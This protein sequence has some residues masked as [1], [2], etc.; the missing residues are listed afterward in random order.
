MKVRHLITS[1]IIAACTVFTVACGVNNNSTTPPGAKTGM[2]YKSSGFADK[3]YAIRESDMTGKEL[4]TVSSL[5]G[6]LAQ[7][8]AAVYIEGSVGSDADMLSSA[9]R[10]YGFEVEYVTDAW[11][12]VGKFTNALGGKY[13]LYND[14]GD[15]GVSSRDLSINYAAVVS[16]VE[17]YVMVAKSDEQAAKDSGFTLGKDATELSTREVFD[18]YMDRLNKGVLVH[19]EPANRYLRDYAIASKAMCFYSDYYDGDSDVKNDILAWADDNAPILGWTENEI[20]FVTSNSTMSKVTVAAD[21]ACNLSFYSAES[22][23]KLT[24]TKYEERNITPQKGKHY[25]AVV[26]SDGDNIQWQT[27]G[28]A[29]DSRYYGSTYRGDFPVTWTSAPG[30]YDLA[31]D[32]LG[33]MYNSATASDQFIAGPSGAGYVNIAD[34]NEKSLKKYAA[35]TAGY[36][37]KTDMSYINFLDNTVAPDRLKYF[38]AYP[39]IKGGVWSVGNKYIEG[40]GA[41]YWS[42]GKP[43]VAARETLWRIAGDDNSN[44]YYGYTERVAQRING[45]TRDYTKIEG[46]TVVLA[47]AWSIGSMD[48]V[49]R[50]VADLDDDVELVTVGEMLNMITEYVPHKNATPNDITPDYFD[51]NLAPISS[52]Q[53]DWAKVRN[54]LATNQ[55]LFNFANRNDLGGFVLA[56]AGK[57]YDKAVWD[58]SHGGSIMLDGSDL[59]DFSDILPNAWIYNM[60]QLSETVHEIKITVSASDDGDANLRIRMLY[61]ND[62]G[63]VVANVLDGAYDKELSVDGYYLLDTGKTFIFDISDYAGKKVLLSIEQDDTGEGSGEQV[64]VSRVAIDPESSSDYWDID[65]IAAEWDFG[66][67]IET[68]SEGVCLECYGDPAFVSCAVTVPTDGTTFKLCLRKFYRPSGEQDQNPRVAVYVNGTLVRAVGADSDFV[69]ALG[70]DAVMYE[71]DL[72][73]YAGQEVTVKIE[74]TYGEHAC[75][76]CVGFRFPDQG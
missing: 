38:S 59:N 68:H 19:Q 61:E 67:K 47:H 64:F 9:S 14:V 55:K 49:A 32:T 51:D 23:E 36:M 73:A 28:F 15:S 26:M 11:E 2:F 70:D 4:T 16:S 72:S 12:L 44:K 57:E 6:I 25:V 37:E 20:N 63:D 27:R 45:Y 60:L 46:Y 50:F 33:E 43:F 40:D 18:T 3:V 7:D 24:Q 41:V 5:Q 29:S 58:S 71:Y 66:G 22:S 10:K 8:R 65:S 31:P 35:Y 52:E 17:H 75:L 48:Y 53:I 30:L 62:N 74:N 69:T 1:V 76:T 39:Q 13:V 21:W 42:N 56:N 54:M 34:Y